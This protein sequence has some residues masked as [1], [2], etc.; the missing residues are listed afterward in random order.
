MPVAPSFKLISALAISPSYRRVVCPPP[1]A[2]RLDAPRGP[3]RSPPSRRCIRRLGS[4]LSYGRRWKH[5]RPR[6]LR[7]D[8]Q[9]RDILR[10]RVSRG[11][12]LVTE[13]AHHHS[14]PS[15]HHL[16]NLAARHGD[17]SILRIRDAELAIG[18]G[19]ADRA[20]FILSLEGMSGLPN[21]RSRSCPKVHKA[22]H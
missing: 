14:W 6:P 4:C 9:S 18:N 3:V 22:G 17:G 13:I 1:P 15:D 8:H 10:V 12:F 20:V 11:F 2:P 21:R 19:T 7:Q 16:A 5:E